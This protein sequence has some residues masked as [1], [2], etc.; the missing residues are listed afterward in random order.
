MDNS[1]TKGL[2]QENLRAEHEL[3]LTY[4]YP[5]IEKVIE[6]LEGQRKKRRKDFPAYTQEYVARKAGISLST[7]RGYVKGRSY[8]IDL[9]TAKGIADVLGCRLSDIIEKAER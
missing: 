2:K 6:T 9:L 7:Y 8:H 1:R 5:F 4:D 3:D